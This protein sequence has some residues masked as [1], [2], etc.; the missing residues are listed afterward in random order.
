MVS[1][2]TGGNGAGI[3]LEVRNLSVSYS[4]S[5]APVL[6]DVSLVVPSGELVAIIGPNGGGKSTLLKTALGL[7]RPRRGEVRLRGGLSPQ[8]AR[9]RV[10]YVPQTEMVDW[11]FPVSVMDVVLMGR[12][13]RL[14]L[15]RR[16]GEA[17]RAAAREALDR[18]GM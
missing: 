13:G 1:N 12:Y 18:V 5:A 11:R 6:H 9:A 17:D 2:G 15:F 8:R 14:G 3:A 10:G 16:P 7:V 4:G